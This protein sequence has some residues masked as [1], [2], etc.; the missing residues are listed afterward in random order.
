M[1][2]ACSTLLPSFHEEVRKDFTLPI[3]ISGADRTAG[4]TRH[5]P[6]LCLLVRLLFSYSAR[7]RRRAGNRLLSECVTDGLTGGVQHG[8]G[9]AFQNGGEDAEQEPERGECELQ[10]AEQTLHPYVFLFLTIG[11]PWLRKGEKLMG[12]SHSAV[13]LSYLGLENTEPGDAEVFCPIAAPRYV[14]G[15]EWD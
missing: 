5:P 6:P 9:D 7:L 12:G 10:I 14:L 15:G 1:Q 13:D 11:C 8:T 3:A 4:C 2:I